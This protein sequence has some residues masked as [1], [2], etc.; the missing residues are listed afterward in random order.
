MIEAERPI[1]RPRTLYGIAEIRGAAALLVLLYHAARH[2]DASVG[3]PA[4]MALFQAGHM[5]VDLFFVLSGFLILHVHARDIGRPAGLRHY[6]WQRFSRVMP[7]YWLALGLTI[8]RDLAAGHGWPDDT[9]LIAS[10]LLLPGWSEPILGPAWSLHHEVLFYLAFALLILRRRTGLAL[11]GIWVLAMVAGA[12]GF[13]PD[14]LPPQVA[15]AYNL[16]FLMGLTAA[17]ALPHIRR[18]AVVA[19]IGG[20]LLAVSAALENVGL[21]DGYGTLAR[22]CYGVPSALLVAGIA[23]S[24]R[25]QMPRGWLARIGDAA[26]SV[27]L[28]QLLFM[29]VAVKVWQATGLERPVLAV[30]LF[31]TMVAAGAG[32]GML[33]HRLVERPLLD[34]M[35]GHPTLLTRMMR[36]R[37][38]PPIG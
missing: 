25:T 24:S 23:A 32:G 4:L 3:A 35:R 18:G 36:K 10:T 5:G 30:P 12:A 1:G 17:L 9:S 7:L 19:T 15:G 14:A 13:M 22:F 6:A 20:C 37:A 11:F 16:E 8:A 26:Y 29:G 38:A 34:A 28:F 21:L 31:L 27:Y 2:V 33:I